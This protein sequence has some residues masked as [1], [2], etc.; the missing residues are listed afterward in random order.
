MAVADKLNELRIK[1][2]LIADKITGMMDITVEVHEG[3]AVL[4]GVVEDQEQ[5]RAAEDLAYEVEGIHEVVNEIRVSPVH[6]D[7]TSDAHLGYSLAQ[8]DVSD[9][10]FAI[11]GESAGPDANQPTS[12]Q[13]PG[14]F[15]DSEIEDQVHERL[16]FQDI[17]D[18]SQVK[19][20]SINQIVHL[21]G[22]VATTEDLYNL[23]D[24]VLNTR[25]VMGISSEVA[26]TE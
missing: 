10:P 14:Q 18:A 13:F 12:E 8:G 17:V 21:T 19:L 2:S 16:A 23:H 3:V 25:G 6:E 15:S 22:S 7:E 26:V 4:Q 20:R 5:K 9:T 11:A 24:V 1:A